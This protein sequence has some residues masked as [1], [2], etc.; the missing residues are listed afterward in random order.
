MAITVKLIMRAIIELVVAVQVAVKRRQLFPNNILRSMEEEYEEDMERVEQIR[1]MQSVFNR[2]R[3]K[4]RI[5][6][7]SWKENGVG[8]HC[9]HFQ[10]DDWYWNAEASFFM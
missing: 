3:D 2:E 1:R 8:A 7:E 9:Q 5:N 6:Y 4:Y 10:R